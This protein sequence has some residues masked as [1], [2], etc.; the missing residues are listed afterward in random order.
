MKFKDVHDLVNLG[1]FDKNEN[2]QLILKNQ[3]FDQGIIDF[4]T[5]LGFSFLIAKKLDLECS[6]QMKHLF[7]EKG[8]PLDFDHYSAYDFTPENADICRKETMRQAFDSNGY[9]KTHTIPN[10]IEEMDR[11]KVSHSVILAIELAVASKNSKHILDKINNNKRLIPFASFHPF[12]LNKR[13]K[14]EYYIAMGARGIKLHPPIQM[15]KPS[16]RLYLDICELAR[17]YDLPIL[18]H[19]GH[20]PLS[21]EFERKYV[22]VSDFE[23]VIKNFPDVTFIMGH[24]GIDYY[25]ETAELGRKYENVYLELSGQPPHAIKEMIDIMGSEKLLFGSDWPFYPVAFPLAKVLIATEGNDKVREQI[26]KTNAEHLLAKF[27]A[28]KTQPGI[29]IAKY[30]LSNLFGKLKI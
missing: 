27:P 7:P 25:K 6:C 16:N 22:D 30:L 5:H 17:E 26:L 13:E 2:D 19:T 21:P 29:S 28:R 10:I 11:M 15:T 20:S 12:T 3:V 24:S 8:N 4:H 18:F 9:S 14:L 1:Y 23:A